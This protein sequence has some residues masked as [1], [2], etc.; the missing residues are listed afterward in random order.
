MDSGQ[1][2]F[3]SGSFFTIKNMLR[4]TVAGI[5]VATYKFLA[6]E[7]TVVRFTLDRYVKLQTSRPSL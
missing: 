4:Q 3:K 5:Y 2:T 6:C 1:S 7:V